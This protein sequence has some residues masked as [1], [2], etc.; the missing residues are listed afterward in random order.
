[1][2]WWDDE[3]LM[4]S[5]EFVMNRLFPRTARYAQAEVAIEAATL[6]HQ[7]LLPQPGRITLFRL[8]PLLES[9][10]RQHFLKVKREEPNHPL[11]SQMDT[12][13]VRQPL[14]DALLTLGLIDQANLDIVKTKSTDGNTLMT[15]T[16]EP[17]QLGMDLEIGP[18]VQRLAAGY[19]LGSR[20]SLVIPFYETAL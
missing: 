13:D 10:V 5:G 1:M 8:P 14:A 16:I 11:T 19:T 7:T 4:E 3:S 17:G 2:A 6:R 9:A 20:G 15:G 12:V 18:I